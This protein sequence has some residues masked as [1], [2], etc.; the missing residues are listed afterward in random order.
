MKPT[1]NS[2]E[3]VKDWAPDLAQKLDRPVEKILACGLNA[4]DFSS[5]RSVEIHYYPDHTIHFESAFAI[6]I[7]TG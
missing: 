1:R 2:W 6:F 7:K 5:S 3:V 4:R